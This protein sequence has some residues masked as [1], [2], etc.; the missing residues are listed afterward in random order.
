LLYGYGYVLTDARKS[1][2]HAVEARKHL[3]LS[4][5]EYS[6]HDRITP[7]RKNRGDIQLIKFEKEGL[8]LAKYSFNEV[9]ESI[10]KSNN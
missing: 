7:S 6:T 9:D 3:V 2:R 4:F 10:I 8:A 5:F 1:L